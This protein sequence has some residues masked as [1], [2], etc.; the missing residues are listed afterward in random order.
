MKPMSLSSA[1]KYLLKCPGRSAG[2]NHLLA[3]QQSLW[4]PLAELQV[5]VQGPQ[6]KIDTRILL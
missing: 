4:L 2:V 6:K 5:L 3:Q 1:Q